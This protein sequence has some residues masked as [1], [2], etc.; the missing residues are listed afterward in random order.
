MPQRRPGKRPAAVASRLR[1]LSFH[2][3]LVAVLAGCSVAEMERLAT[4]KDRD[5]STRVTRDTGL[6]Q[7]V[8]AEH[9]TPESVITGGRQSLTGHTGTLSRMAIGNTDE[10]QLIDPVAVGGTE[11]LLYIVDADPRVVYRYDLV[12]NEMEPLPDIASHL[13]G[14]PGNIYVARDRSFYLVDSIGQQVLH[15]SEQGQLIS[16]F[17]D[18]ANLSRPIDVVVDEEGGFVYVADASYSHIVVFNNVGRALKLIGKRGTGPGHFRTI[19]AM[20]WGDDGLFITDRIQL[21][22]QVLNIAGQYRYSFGESDLHYPSA[23]A[24]DQDQFVFVADRH[25][26]N[27]RIYQH[28]QLVT[29]FGG[30][31]SAPGKFH[32]ITDLWASG[33]L[34]YVAD[35]MNGRVQVLRIDPGAAPPVEPVN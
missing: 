19:T 35:S 6:S 9:L 29:T 16:Q 1:T 34:L 10:Y 11:D 26:N 21:P 25:D 8:G 4:E 12:L 30:G 3:L 32:I 13:R 18:L 20:T 5:Q 15:F 24:V 28:G 2:A 31:G 14:R 22:V 17:Q 7:K 27:I 33:N 23:V